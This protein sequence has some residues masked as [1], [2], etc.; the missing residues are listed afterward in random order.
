MLIGNIE[1]SEYDFV[2]NH[3]KEL[4]TK[5]FDDKHIVNNNLNPK[6]WNFYYEVVYP[7]LLE[8]KAA[9]YVIYNGETPICVR[10]L[11]F[12]ET[13]IFDAIT[14]FDID[15]TKFH[16]GKISIMKMLEWSFKNDFKIFDFSKGYFDYKESW[17]DLRYDFEYHLFIDSKS[18]TSIILGNTIAF[19]LKFK[20]YLREK[21]INKTLHKLTY[22]L[23]RRKTYSDTLIKEISINE[24]NYKQTQLE[25]IKLD[26]KHAFLKKYAYDFLFI[27]KE[28]FKNLK[29]YK[30]NNQL[31]T[32]YL[33]EV[34]EHIKILSVT[35]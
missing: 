10:L 30:V 32:I 22:I 16:I 24:I 6:E 25:P 13:I 1:K 14:V 20:Q 11:Y 2:F 4:L 7:L 29:V 21:E 9:L 33:L 18:I 8:K 23:R 35:I 3:F 26:D 19:L 15:Y 5:R 17:S 27:T 12:S 34:N 28:H 31:N